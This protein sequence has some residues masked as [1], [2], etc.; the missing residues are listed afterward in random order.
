M[1]ISMKSQRILGEFA[2]NI[3]RL[4]VKINRISAWMLLIFM[5]IFLV[6]GYAWSNRIILPLQ[7]AKYMH[8]NLDLFLVFFFLVHVLISARFTLARWRVGHRRLVSGMLIAIGIAAFWI[9]LTIR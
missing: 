6:S 7:Q 9:V 3:G 5:I 1:L 4:L 8:T 2:L